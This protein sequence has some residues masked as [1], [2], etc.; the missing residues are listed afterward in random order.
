MCLDPPKPIGRVSP[1]PNFHWAF[2]SALALPLTAVQANHPQVVVSTRHYDN[3]VGTSDA[4]SEGVIRADLLASRPAQRPGEVLEFVP[5][6]IVTQHSGDGKANQIFLRGFNLDHGTDFATSINGVPVNMPSHAHGQGYSDLNFLMPELVQRVEYRKGPYSARNGD[7]SL[8]GSADIT[9]RTRLDMPF[10][11]LAL[12]QRGFRRGVLGGSMAL[13]PSGTTALAAVEVA[14]H[15][16]PWT[17]PQGLRRLNGV[18]TLSGGDD[19]DAWQVSLMGYDAS[20]TATDQ[21]PERAIG[22]TGLVSGQSR[23]FG[24]YD[25][26][27]PTAGG[28]TSRH[29]LSGQWIHNDADGGVWRTQAYAVR[30][31]MDLYSNFTYALER[32]QQGD[33]FR[34]QDD[35]WVWGGQVGRA[36]SHGLAGRLARTEWGL[37]W[38]HDDARVGLYD[39]V[40]RRVTNTVR[41]DDVQQTLASLHAQTMVEWSPLVRT[42]TGL[43]ADQLDAR[44]SSLSNPLNS[45]H[46]RD[47]ILSPKFSMVLGPWNKSELFINAGSGFHSNDARGGT[48]RVDPRSGEPVRQVPLLVPGRG[49]ELG[50]RTEAISGLQTSLALW[51]LRLNSELVY[52]GDAGVTEASQASRRHGVELSNRWAPKSWMLVDADVAW[53]QG[54]LANGDRIPNAVD[55]VASAALTLKDLGLWSTS[56]QW[57]YLGGGPLVEDNSVRSHPSSTFNARVGRQLPGWGRHADV[58]VDVFNLTNRRVNDIQYFYESRLPG[59]AQ[60]VGDRHLHPAEPRSIRLTLRL[61]F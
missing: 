26:L 60:A 30:Y 41:L 2:A 42:I 35:R 49:A 15:D 53:S 34:Q 43:R 12:G 61:G 9:Y 37:Q 13:G 36:L 59:E 32:P 55:R 19:I 40:A 17:V 23:A 33:Q 47:A 29:S 5:G 44:V 1:N 57:R 27:D 54:R 22:Q 50:L 45:G 48:I 4:A 8:A 20:W 16:G 25:S 3:A 31:G 58:S 10:M 7:F 6:V 51:M 56:L 11:D 52:V 18:F 39:S 14:G 21:I 28:L 24:R 46:A 38:R